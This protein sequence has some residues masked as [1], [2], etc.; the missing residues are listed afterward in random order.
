MIYEKSVT[1]WS[2]MQ[3]S[4]V[5]YS[6]SIHPLSKFSTVAGS[7]MVIGYFWSD[8]TFTFVDLHALKNPFY[9]VSTLFN[10]QC[11]D[12]YFFNEVE[13]TRGRTSV[14]KSLGKYLRT[15]ENKFFFFP[16]SC[17][18]FY[19]LPLT[20]NQIIWSYFKTIWEKKP[21]MCQHTR[22]L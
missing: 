15:H 17:F 19:Y 11:L 6:S 22:R 12:L 20:A 7:S 14:N 4:Q 1:S 16:L 3:Q 13:T 10:D 21:S 9:F 5:E 2:H 18:S 8:T